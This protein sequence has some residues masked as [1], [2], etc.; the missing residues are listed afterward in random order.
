M[1]TNDLNN[2]RFLN[3]KIVHERFTSSYHYDLTKATN[4]L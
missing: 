3:S 2:F 1:I 4:I